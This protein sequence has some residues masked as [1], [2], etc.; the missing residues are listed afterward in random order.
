M[1]IGDPDHPNN[2]PPAQPDPP[3]PANPVGP[4]NQQEVEVKDNK[5][6]M[7][8]IAI[9]L[10]AIFGL[11]LYSLKSNKTT[12]A[13]PANLAPIVQTQQEISNTLK[14]IN[15]NQRTMTVTLEALPEKIPTP[16]LDCEALKEC[17]KPKPRGNT[18]RRTPP[19]PIITYRPPSQNVE[20]T[21]TTECHG[22]CGGNPERPNPPS[23]PS[24]EPEAGPQNV[25]RESNVT[26][27]TINI[28]VDE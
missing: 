20:V 2:N 5:T 27:P 15:E 8:I 21:V 14:N 18:R 1:A 11:Q 4:N 22:N 7:A 19:G 23:T 9:A 6:L 10:V 12:T 17:L 25:R 28:R 3:D 26:S 16:V 24:R 13:E